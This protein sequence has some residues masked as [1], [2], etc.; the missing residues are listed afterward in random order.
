MST[1]R[2]GWGKG[3]VMLLETVNRLGKIDN[4][5]PRLS[6]PS[7]ELPVT[8]LVAVPGNSAPPGDHQGG[9]VVWWCNVNQ[10]GG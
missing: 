4:K 3:V 8:H 10:G 5:S 2:A 1:A 6:S 7:P 9:G